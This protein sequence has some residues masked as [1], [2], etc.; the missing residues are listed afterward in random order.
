MELVDAQTF[1]P[2][3]TAG[4]KTVLLVAAFFGKTRLIDNIR[5]DEIR[6]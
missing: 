5:L 3:E 1:Q 4:M 6:S 2:V